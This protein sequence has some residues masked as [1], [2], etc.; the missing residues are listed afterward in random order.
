MATGEISVLNLH[1]K[2]GSDISNGDYFLFIDDGVLSKIL[3]TDL[4]ASV[5][6]DAKGD[7]GDVGATG[8]VGGQGAIGWSPLLAV[9]SDGARRV[10][11][12][13]DW[14]GST[15][16]KPT[17][18]QYLTT[19]GFTTNI[20]LA[21]D[22][23]GSSG[24]NGTNGTN[25]TI[26]ETGWSPIL[27]LIVDGARRVYQVY[28]WTGG[29]GT[30]PATGQYI[31]T[32]G[33]TNVL[34][35]ATDLVGSVSSTTSAISSGLSN[36]NSTI[37]TVS[38]GL[39]VTTSSL[40]S[41]SSGL[42]SLSSGLSNTS[43]SVSAISS[44]LSTTTSSV[45]SVSSGLSDVSTGLSNT[46]SSVS[47]ISSGLSSVSSGLSNTNTSVSSIS[48]S[49]STLNGTLGDTTPNTAVVTTLRVNTALQLPQVTISTLPSATTYSG[50]LV[51]VTD[52]TGGAKV[53]RSD[54]TAWKI[55]N[56]TVTVT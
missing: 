46:N 11:Q 40:S 39:S 13:Y 38:S 12:V 47:T 45:S 34:A 3:K 14:T 9:V 56:T 41:V 22:I 25:G 28:D 54:G 17:I 1:L 29:T 33:F 16:T 2:T 26:G 31:G 20:T 43:S 15:G 24:S 19:T 30:K 23:R 5:A 21:T 42:S 52:A 44:G 4:Y 37:S 8:A 7:K 49:L 10:L 51:D 35:S 48:S 53:C 50:Y 36:T 18:G 27:A 32:S 55:L 6:V